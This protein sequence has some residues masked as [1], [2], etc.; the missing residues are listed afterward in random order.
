MWHPGVGSVDAG[1]AYEEADSKL[2]QTCFEFSLAR[3]QKEVSSSKT[4]TAFRTTKA[5][6]IPGGQIS[7]RLPD[8]TVLYLDR[9]AA[10]SEGLLQMRWFRFGNGVLKQLKGI[11]IG[12]PTG[13]LTSM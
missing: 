11:P 1:Q 6:T 7:Y 5:I 4:V 2:V 3:Y 9:C 13:G 12:S 10:I 8:R